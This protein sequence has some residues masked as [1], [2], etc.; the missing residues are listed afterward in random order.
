MRI[1]EIFAL[2][3]KSGSMNTTVTSDLR[4]EVE[5]WP[6]RARAM[7]PAKIIGEFKKII[8]L[9]NQDMCTL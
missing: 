5:V 2:L 8:C 7:H 4:A 6:F 3:R 1:A 9:K